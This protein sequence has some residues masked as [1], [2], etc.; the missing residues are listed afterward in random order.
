[1]SNPFAH[2]VAELHRLQHARNY[3]PSEPVKQKAKRFVYNN[4]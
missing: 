1:M 2:I 4:N 3:V